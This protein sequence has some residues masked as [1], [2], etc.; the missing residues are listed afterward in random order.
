MLPVIS[1]AEA[2]RC[3]A[4][5]IA[6]RLAWLFLSG[7]FRLMTIVTFRV[8]A[9]QKRDIHLAALVSS[10]VAARSAEAK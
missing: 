3:A 2:Q 4:L 7:K 6:E 10:R 1:N 9:K 5:L 8:L